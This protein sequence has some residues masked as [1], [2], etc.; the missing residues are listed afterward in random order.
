MELNPKMQPIFDYISEMLPCTEDAI[1]D[2]KEKGKL[3][4]LN[5]VY[6]KYYFNSKGQTV[7]K[8]KRIYTDDGVISKNKQLCFKP[9]VVTDENVKAFKKELSK[10]LK[11]H[12]LED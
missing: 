5:Q 6:V 11:K 7:F 8:I 12:G 4:F 2:L 3:N 9:D 1:P 10:F